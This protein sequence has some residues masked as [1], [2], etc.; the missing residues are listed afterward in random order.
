MLQFAE[1]LPFVQQRLQ[2]A[3]S[4]AATLK[5]IEAM[6][7][8][9]QSNCFLLVELVEV[10]DAGKPIVESTYILE[11][12][13]ALAWKCYQ[14]LI[15]IQNSVNV[16]NLPNL[17]AVSRHISGGNPVVAQQCYP[18]GVAAVQSGWDYFSQTVMGTLNG[19]VE[20]FKAARLF[21]PYQICYLR[22]VAND[23]DAISFLNNAAVTRDFKNEPPK[24]LAKAD[25]IA[26]DVDPVG[27]WK[28]N[29]DELPFW[30]AAAKLA[31]LLQPSSAS[32]ERVFSILTTR[33]GHLQ[34]LAL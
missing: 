15:F 32:S 3:G 29:A 18:Y 16:V 26:P 19:Q 17:T 4:K 24:Y 34:D 10:V 6:L 13:D 25:G 33:F 14:Q 28:N 20:I 1:I 12:D 8:D 22:P 7:N 27:W 30:S 23:I 21:S 2:E 9:V 5:Q 11:G 31:L